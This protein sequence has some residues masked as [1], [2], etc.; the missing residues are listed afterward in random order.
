MKKM[1]DM[2]FENVSGITMHEDSVAEGKLFGLDIDLMDYNFMTFDD[3]SFDVLWARQSLHYPP[4]PFFTIVEMN[5]VMKTG[6]WAYI[7]IP[8]PADSTYYATLHVD[9]YKKLFQR[10]GFEVIQQ[11]SYELTAEEAFE[12]HNF[13]IVSKQISLTLP[14]FEE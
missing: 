5:R 13:I 4:F 1:K 10:A 14:E 8:E 12:K 7:E 6:G 3:S 11:D 2:G 9:T